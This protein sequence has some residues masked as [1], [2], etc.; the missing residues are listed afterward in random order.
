MT[1]RA[2]RVRA[3]LPA[4]LA[5]LA[6]GGCG[7]G[8]ATSTE[9][10]SLAPREERQAAQPF[11]AKQ[12]LISAG[13][14]DFVV[15]GCSGCHVIGSGRS[16]GPNFEGFAG[17]YVRLADGRRVLIDEAFLQRALSHPLQDALPGYD[18]RPMQR[19]LERIGL[20]SRTA[21]VQQLAAFIEEIGPE[22]G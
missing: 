3:A 22:P 4:T 1:L 19:A 17:H 9:H 5:A 8:G 7:S 11:T 2:S 6:V 13:A 16:A 10:L 18:P 12:E 20:P 21:Q 15:D 14:R